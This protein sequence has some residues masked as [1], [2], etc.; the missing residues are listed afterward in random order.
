MTCLYIH[1]YIRVYIYT[2]IYV[3][4]CIYIYTYNYIHIPTNKW[5]DDHP[6]FWEY[7][8]CFDL[9][10]V[11]SQNLEMRIKSAN[12]VTHSLSVGFTIGISCQEYRLFVV[13]IGFRINNLCKGFFQAIAGLK[14]SSRCFI[15]SMDEIMSALQFRAVTIVTN[16]PFTQ[17]GMQ[18][19]SSRSLTK[20]KLETS[21]SRQ[22]WVMAFL[23][24]SLIGLII[25]HRSISAVP[26][27]ELGW[28]RSVSSGCLEQFQCLRVAVADFMPCLVD[29]LLWK[30]HYGIR[31][32]TDE[33]GKNMPTYANYPTNGDVGAN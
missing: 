9:A 7:K 28:W 18:C 11:A 30:P 29:D 14:W 31:M 6:L 13:S 20:H 17:F 10:H 23:G 33:Y 15:Q 24:E 16:V 22:S 21:S 5:I 8:P 2:Y 32:N 19:A 27:A 26:V 4:T 1:I 12:Q 25:K 3:Y